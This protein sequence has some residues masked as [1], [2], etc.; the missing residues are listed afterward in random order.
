MS[1]QEILERFTRG[2]PLEIGKDAGFDEQ[3]DDDLEKV[4]HMD[5]VDREEYVDKLKKT[6]KFYDAQQ[7]ARAEK[8]QSELDKKAVEELV[9]AK[10]AAEEAAEKSKGKP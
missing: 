6:K 2:E 9:S 8:R 10:L 4:Q 1:L 3:G 7:K 5:L